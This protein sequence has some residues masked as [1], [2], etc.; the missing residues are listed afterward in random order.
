MKSFL[1]CGLF[2][3]LVACGGR[4]SSHP[5]D[6]TSPDTAEPGP[7]PSAPSPTPGVQA[8]ADSGDGTE[9]ASGETIYPHI[10]PAS[11]GGTLRVTH[12]FTFEDRPLRITVD[13]RRAIIA[14]AALSPRHSLTRGNRDA[15]WRARY[16]LAFIDDP[17]QEDFYDAVLGELRR[18]KAKHNLDSD[19]YAE[20]IVSMVQHIEYD[21]REDGDARFPVETFAAKR[22]DC[23]DKS[24][25]L[26]GLLAREGYG[27]ATLHF[28]QE[29]HMAA[30]IRSD[31][32]EYRK[33]GYAYIE[34]TS[35]SM[36][37]FPFEEGADV[38]LTTVPDAFPIGNGTIRYTA[39]HEVKFLADTFTRLDERIRTDSVALDAQNRRCEEAARRVSEAQAAVRAAK[40]AP[41]DELNR[42]IGAYNRAVDDY[43][44]EVEKQ[45]EMA[46]QMNRFIEVR[47]YIAAHPADRYNTFRRVKQK[48]E[49]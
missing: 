33:T 37:G 17:L 48:L 11:D 5:P 41:A 8:N 24:R 12:A 43:N 4:P 29:N 18:L 35:P 26:A 14:G 13:I 9:P 44:T 40:N 21:T 1:S 31:A 19:R 3:L 2:V 42:H 45:K 38:R 10:L 15:D 23:D 16:N 30:G 27:V 28:S 36:I 47:N 20:L 39:A 7:G 25:L 49:D 34:T 22:G 46:Q 6:I 32:L